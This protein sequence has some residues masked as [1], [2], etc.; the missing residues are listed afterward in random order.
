MM[1]CC[2]RGVRSEGDSA[3]SLD[4]GYI[5]VQ[6]ISVIFH[7]LFKTAIISTAVTDE[8][9]LIILLL[10]LLLVVLVSMSNAVCWFPHS[11]F[12]IDAI[13]HAY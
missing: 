5:H 1:V 7:S 3:R 2:R 10:L 6:Y 13:N 12:E 4:D 9:L 8:V 11:D